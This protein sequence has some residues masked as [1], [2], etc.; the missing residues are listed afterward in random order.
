MLKPAAELRLEPW[1]IGKRHRTRCEQGAE[2]RALAFEGT[3]LLDQCRK[4]PADSNGLGQ[5]PELRLD[6]VQVRRDGRTVYRDWGGELGADAVKG[7]A[8][9]F[10][11]EN[12]AGDR[13]KHH[14]L[15]GSQR[16]QGP[17][18]ADRPPPVEGNAAGI[19]MATPPV[20]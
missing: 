5:V 1:P 13:L 17:V 7:A 16:Q 18:V 9:H 20:P 19:D 3:K 8:D 4:V 6:A 2:S 10:R 11:M 15:G 12:I 14:R